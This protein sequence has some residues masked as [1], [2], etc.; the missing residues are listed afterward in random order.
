MYVCMYVCMYVYIYLIYIFIYL[1]V[2]DKLQDSWMNLNQTFCGD[3]KS[4]KKVN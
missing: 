2:R 1:F 3:S 4:T